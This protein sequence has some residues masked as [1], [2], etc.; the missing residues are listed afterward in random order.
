VPDGV[1]WH[2]RIFRS[3]AEGPTSGGAPVGAGVHVGGRKIVTCAHVIEAALVLADITRRPAEHVW[4]DF[5]QSTDKRPRRAQVVDDAWFPKRDEAGDLAV[6]EIVD[7]DAAL[8]TPA[9]LRLVGSPGRQTIKVLGHPLGQLNGVWARARLIGP[10]GP[11]VEW[12]QMDTP[13]L[14]GKRIQPGFS[15]AG[16]IDEEDGT[17]IGC[18]VAVDTTAE[19]R[20]AWMIPT[21]VIAAYWPQLRAMCLPAR[22]RGQSRARKKREIGPL[23]EQQWR[24]LAALLHAHSGIS[25]R[26]ER[27]LHIK[28]LERRFDERLYIERSDVDRSDGDY[29]ATVAIVDACAAHPGA[30]H[31][32]VEQLAKFQLPEDADVF[33]AIAAAIETVDPSPLLIPD[34]RNHL[35]RVL[36]TIDPYVRADM[37]IRSYHEAV[38]P[39]GQSEI[40][41]L[42]L[43]SVAR[44]LESSTAVLG[45][46]P[47][48][49]H[50]IEAL[51]RELPPARAVDLYEWVDDFARREG[52][53]RGQIARLRLSTPPSPTSPVMGYLLTEVTP[54]GADSERY[55]PRITLQQT[56]QSGQLTQGLL[57]YPTEER[58]GDPVPWSE[59]P[60]LFD[61]ALSRVWTSP[62]APVSDLVVEFL[63]PFPLLNEPVDQWEIET[64]GP[65]HVV[66]IDHVVVVRIWDRVATLHSLNRSMPHWEQKSSRLNSEDARVRW[67]DPDDRQYIT[68]RLYIDLLPDGEPCLGLLRSPQLPPVPGNDAVSIGI[69]TG[70]PAMIWCRD[71]T[72]STSFSSRMRDYLARN[73]LPELPG[74]ILQ[75]RRESVRTGDPVGANITLV[76][77]LADRLAPAARHRSQ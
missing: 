1:P 35:Y 61:S 63:L 7:A 34:E 4:V 68:G 51:C 18:V 38:P 48:L 32:L 29:D 40:D 10:A 64:S 75:L 26:E 49:I 22:A 5:P 30:L 13:T 11:N 19:D 41:P 50:F 36:D 6:L 45:D 24:R 60:E 76:W 20:I 59:I 25:R 53:D 74:F 15:G 23:S 71:D 56:A 54:D 33:P 17:V 52:I 73:G 70:V 47:P 65:A 67:V 16:V 12:I 14:T 62:G 27:L 42:D 3:S 72:I 37:V 57:L 43:P 77:D 2:A 44:Q 28:W 66:G 46:V 39:L 9:P 58:M 31:S 55:L 21:D 8:G 69:R